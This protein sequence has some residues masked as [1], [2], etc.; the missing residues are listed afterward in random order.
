[1]FTCLAMSWKM[2]NL[3]TIFVYLAEC[4]LIQLHYVLCKESNI[5]RMFGKIQGCSQQFMYNIHK[6]PVF[7][8]KIFLIFF[9][10]RVHQA[11][12]DGCL[13]IIHV[14]MYSIHVS[15]QVKNHSS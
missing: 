8:T 6:V 11:S 7:R 12:P 1:M 13:S 4:I 10:P 2:E 9:L 5:T 14:S 15:G 3:I